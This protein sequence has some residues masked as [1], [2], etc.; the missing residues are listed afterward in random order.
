M[1]TFLIINHDRVE[2]ARHSLTLSLHRILSLINIGRSSV[3][4]PLS[5]ADLSMYVLHGLPIIIKF[6]D[7]ENRF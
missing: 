3:W 2:R 7:K 1:M 6:E 5:S 4:Q